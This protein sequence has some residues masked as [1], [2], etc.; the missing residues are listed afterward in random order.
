MS[1]GSGLAKMTA[2]L[3]IAQADTVAFGDAMND[4]SMLTWAGLGVAMANAE[5]VVPAADR[6]T[7]SNLDDGVAIVIEELTG[8]A[9]EKQPPAWGVDGRGGHNGGAIA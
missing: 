2:R 6:V 7:A 3:G 1:K 9:N 5:D 8:I 4:V